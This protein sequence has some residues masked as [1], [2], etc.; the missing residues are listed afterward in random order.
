MAALGLKCACR[1]APLLRTRSR[2]P[3]VRSAFCTTIPWLAG[4]DLHVRL[5]DSS[6]VGV[7]GGESGI[8]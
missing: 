8:W 3:M 4:F 1:I 5:H 7:Y 6:L 2:H